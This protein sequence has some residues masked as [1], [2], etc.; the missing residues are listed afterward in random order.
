MK[1]GGPH[2]LRVSLSPAYT[3]RIGT[4]HLAE[5]RDL[6]DERAYLFTFVSGVEYEL[7]VLDDRLSNV[8]FVKDYAY[9]ARAQRWEPTA[10]E[11]AETERG[12]HRLGAGDEL[13]Y[14]VTPWLYAKASY[15]YATRL[16][17]PE[18]VFGNGILIDPNVELR[19]EISHN[20]NLGPRAELEHTPAGDFTLDVNAFLRESDDLIVFFAGQTLVPYI[21]VTEVRAFGLENALGWTS[22]GRFVNVDGSLTWQDIRT[23]ADDGKFGKQQGQ[24]IPSKPWLFGSFGLRLRFPVESWHAAVEPYYQGRY[25]HAFPRS[26]EGLGL[27]EF[28]VE[29]PA[30]T[31]HHLGVIW[32]LN[33]PYGRF[34]STFEASNVDERRAYDTF[35][36]EKAGRGYSLKLTAQL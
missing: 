29:V 22:P 12:I 10:L 7:D 19:P 35:G 13:R 3:T 34:T 33:R 26:W 21:N 20:V 36:V 24:R 23:V 4:D 14:R 25:V 5:A 11:Q 16:P 31:T 9:A 8:A 27:A 30:Q 6:L 17:N 15:E 32:I 28:K 18:E 2:S 1:L